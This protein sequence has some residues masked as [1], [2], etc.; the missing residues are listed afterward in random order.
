MMNK[1]TQGPWVLSPHGR[2]PN[3]VTMF[4]VNKITSVGTSNI[5]DANLI[6]AAPELLEALERLALEISGRGMTANQY[7]ALIIARAAIAKAKG[8]DEQNQR[9]FKRHR[10]TTN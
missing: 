7:E 5:Y 6:A 1:H 8:S 2:M 10:P 3:G 9:N 4:F